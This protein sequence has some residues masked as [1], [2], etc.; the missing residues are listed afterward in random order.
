MK[1]DLNRSKI[2]LSDRALNYGD[3]C[4]TTIALLYGKYQQ[5]QRHFARLKLDSQRLSIPLIQFDQLETELENIARTQEIGRYVVKVLISRGVGGRGYSRSG[6]SSPQYFISIHP[7]PAHYDDWQKRG[8]SIG[9]SAVKLGQQ[10]LL[11]GIKHLNRLEQVLVKQELENSD[12]D[13]LLVL[14]SEE[15]IVESSASNVFWFSKATGWRTPSLYKAGVAGV[16]RDTVINYMTAHDIPIEQDQYLVDTLLGADSVFICN[17][18]M[19]I[20]PVK[21]L[22]IH[23]Q[24]IQYNLQ[25][26]HQLS[27]GL[28]QWISQ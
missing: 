27:E 24:E 20:V 22:Y 17:S 4:F 21:N 28:N 3:G 23:E 5:L 6:C 7:F 16:M 19:G 14:D 26:V 2:L 8:V 11:A 1:S 9:V 18:L 12:L 10:P 13:D 15:M 25:R